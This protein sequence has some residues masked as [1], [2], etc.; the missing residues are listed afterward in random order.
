MAAANHETG[1]VRSGDVSIFYRRFG[2]RGGTPIL[3]AHGANY[4]DSYDWIEVAAE[5]AQGREVVAYDTRG[6]GQSGWSASKNY[7][8]D[9]NLADIKALVDHFEWKKTVFM[10]H[11]RGGG[12]MLLAGARLTDRAAAL[13]LVD[14][15]P[16]GGPAPARPG[17]GAR[18]TVYPTIEAGIAAMSRDKAATTRARL[19]MI[20]TPAEGGF[21][22]RTRDPD[23]GSQVP[24]TPGWTPT[25]VVGDMWRELG[26]VRV[27]TL[28]VRALHGT[29]YTQEII[30]RVRR[31]YPEIKVIDVESGH[32]VAGGAPQA[33]IAGIKRFVGDHVE[34]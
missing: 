24:T 19:D 33:L 3:I 29:N 30:E 27:P 31:D 15:C 1:T 4:Y 7:S 18:A 34:R 5:L 6:F 16:G 28:I 13:I 25:V 11:S 10:G 8:H 26:S 9:A 17:G 14:Y 12:I 2:T 22:F 23:F 32:D 21:L 20:F